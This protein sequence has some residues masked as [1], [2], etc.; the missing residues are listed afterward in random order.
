MLLM[1]PVTWVEGSATVVN[2]RS[3]KFKQSSCCR[4][5]S[6]RHQVYLLQAL[7]SH[8]LTSAGELVPLDKRKG[9]LFIML[10]CNWIKNRPVWLWQ[11][12]RKSRWP[13]WGTL[14]IFSEVCASLQYQREAVTHLAVEGGVEGVLSTTPGHL[15]IQLIT[16]SPVC[17][18]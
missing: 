10:N 7:R 12:P 14:C 16:D 3:L 11:R 6:A 8:T 9:K 4:K 1:T 13:R 17:S 2:E 18:I 15:L 5:V